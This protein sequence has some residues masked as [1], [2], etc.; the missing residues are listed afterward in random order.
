[1]TWDPSQKNLAED[2]HKLLKAWSE[3][4][5]KQ[6]N[7][8]W[9]RLGVRNAHGDVTQDFDGEAAA[10]PESL[11]QKESLVHSLERDERNLARLVWFL[12]HARDLCLDGQTARVIVRGDVALLAQTINHA[13][14]MGLAKRWNDQ[15]TTPVTVDPS[16]HRDYVVGVELTPRGKALADRLSERFDANLPV[17][18][19]AI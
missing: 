10:E 17:E 14:D 6:R 5:A 11:I 16:V 15:G 4:P 1:M 7:A 18:G 19:L 12:R 3:V 9:T 8:Y 2:L 13:V